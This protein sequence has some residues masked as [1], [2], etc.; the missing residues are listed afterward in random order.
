MGAAWSFDIVSAGLLEVGTSDDPGASKPSGWVESNGFEIE[1]EGPVQ[2]FARVT[3]GCDEVSVS[4][5]YEGVSAY[6]PAAGQPGSDAV[7]AQD[8]RFVGWASAVT[9][10]RFGARVDEQFRDAGRALGPPAATAYDVLVLGAGGEVTLTFE[11]PIADGTG[12]DFAVFEN[13][14]RDDFLE[15]AYVEVSSDEE[16]FIRFP[17]AYLGDVPVGAFSVQSAEHLSG[18]AGKYRAG[19]GTPF[20]L[21]VLRYHPEVVSG[22]VDINAITHVRLVDIVGDGASRDAFGNPIYDPYP[23]QGSAGFDLDAVGVIHEAGS[24]E[25]RAG[26]P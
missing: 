3:G 11:L 22:V 10:T 18:L 19:W 5:T 9:E 4:W 2:V 14:F 12:P 6:P 25:C 7:D 21:G 17:A 1:A 24:V 15:L 20:D 8:E 16:H 13:S 26:F 23:T